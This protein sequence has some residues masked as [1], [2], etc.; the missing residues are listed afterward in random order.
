M[1]L[2]LLVILLLANLALLGLGALLFKRVSQ[3]SSQ[4]EALVKLA[5]QAESLHQTLSQQFASSTADMASRLEQTK[6]D[7]RQQVSDRLADGFT[8]IRN[9]VEEQMTSG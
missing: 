1:S 3:A 6:G 4:E 5:H 2:F 7:L 9:A 8:G